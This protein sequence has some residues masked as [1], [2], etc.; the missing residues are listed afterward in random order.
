MGQLTALGI[1]ALREPGRYQDGYGLMLEVGPNGS[2]WWTLRVQV[3]G[4]R[5]DSGLGSFRDVPLAQARENAAALCKQALAGIDPVAAKKRQ[6]ES[7][8]TFAAAA[9]RVHEEHKLG[10]KNGKHQA[11]WIANLENYAF[12]ASGEPTVDQIEG[13][14]V[15][16][17]LATI[18]LEKPETARRVRRRIGTVLDWAYAKGFR[19]TDAPM[20]SLGKGLPR[21]PRKGERHPAALAYAQVPAF[22]AELRR[23]ESIGRLALEL[24]LLT[25][26]RSG[27]MRGRP[28]CSCTSGNGARLGDAPDRGVHCFR[29]QGPRS[30]SVAGVRG[31][32][33]PRARDAAMGGVAG[34]VRPKCDPRELALARAAG[35][36]A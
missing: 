4:K 7:V 2:K 17:V 30:R 28:R 34:V 36:S 22:F 19:A 29:T 33:R 13:P 9:R 26:A 21:Q 11:Q 31:R 3:N 23:R 8:P 32:R 25:A 10:W 35:T 5:C 1:K 12:P 27:E 15:R 14:A 18:L 24:A 20:R 6:R 16:G